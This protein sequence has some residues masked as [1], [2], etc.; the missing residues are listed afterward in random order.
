MRI[1]W[2]LAGLVMLLAAAACAPSAEPTLAVL[3]SAE[4][5]TPV[6]SNTPYVRPTLPPTWTPAPSATPEPT[7]EQV[8]P[9]T[10]EQVPPPLSLELPEGWRFG[11]DTI[12]Y[13]NIGVMDAVRVALYQ[14]PVSG[15]QATI[16]LLWNFSSVTTG[17]PFAQDYG[18][19]SLWLDGLRLLRVL[20]FEAGCNFGTA[21]QKEFNV[22]GLAATGTDFAIV[23]CPELP[24]T[25][26]WFAGLIVN[27][28][29]MIFYMYTDP[30]HAMDGPAPL[31][32]QAILDTVNFTEAAVPLVTATP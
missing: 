7:R 4:P 23:D 32:I 6:P 18:V 17:N 31:E 8:D 29:P 22:G 27:Q 26:G 3:P 10:G 20:V 5:F 21:P 2:I 12:I 1:V 13:D 15:G 19:P 28:M 14:G 11:Y 25:R 16:V 24:D 9:L 30:I